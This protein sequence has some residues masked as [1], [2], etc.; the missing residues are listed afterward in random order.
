MKR[1]YII[2]LVLIGIS[3]SCTKSFEDYNTDKKRPVAV[4]G[5]F[6]FANAQKT[7]ADLEI[8]TNV[9]LNEFNQW[10]QYWTATTYPDETNYDIVNRNVAA[11]NFRWYYRD[12]LKDLEE[13]KMVIK[14]EKPIG[15]AAIAN[16]KNRLFIVDIMQVLVYHNLVNIFGNVP[17][18]KTMDITDIYPAYDDGL[19][20]Y[21]DLIARLTADVAGLDA[22]NTSFASDD[23]YMSGDVAMWKKFGNTLKV[24]L[25]INLADVDAA[26][27]KAAVESAYAGAFADGEGCQLNYLTG[28]NANNF[29]LDFINS[30]RHDFVA[31]TTII[32]AMT[33][34]SDPRMSSYFESNLPTYKGALYGITPAPWNQYTHISG[35]RSKDDPLYNP[36]GKKIAEPMFPGVI[37]NNTELAFYLAEAAERGYT[38]GGT[39]EV[40]Y[41]KAITASLKQWGYSDTEIAAYLANP[42][43]AYTAKGTTKMHQIAT[44]SWIASFGRGLNGFTTWRRLDFPI[45]V[46]GPGAPT[47]ND[48]PKRYTYPV[49]EQTLN[50][51]NYKAAG[52]AIGGDKLT[53]KLFWDK[54]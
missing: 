49:N 8:N 33:G 24:K 15:D 23:I 2:L 27:S 16:Q 42:L 21:K 30:D 1:I 50:P 7:F 28:G 9:N 46:Q 10:S 19:T 38:V 14:A 29:F 20:I 40:L 6:L 13:A 36:T 25:G 47:Y 52:T 51:D 45:L 54:F 37:L 3:T 12:M 31:S 11:T 18:A 26:A 53:T 17:Y 4:P 44:Q 35:D 41:N 48:I 32:N 22:T 39:A 5:G 43:V 34:L